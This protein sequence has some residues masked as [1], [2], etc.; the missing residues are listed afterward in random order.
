MCVCVYVI[1]DEKCGPILEER[2]HSSIMQPKKKEEEEEASLIFNDLYSVELYQRC[3]HSTWH[4][5][6]IV[7]MRVNGVLWCCNQLVC[8]N[9]DN[10]T[11]TPKCGK[12]N[13]FII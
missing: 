10:R 11:T 2:A 13:Y 4:L 1:F 3:R 9:F 12:I 6:M 8:N 7:C 5:Y